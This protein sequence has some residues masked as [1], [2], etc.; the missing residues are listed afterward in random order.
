VRVSVH[1]HG[2]SAGGDGLV[3]APDGQTA[4]RAPD[5]S[6]LLFGRSN[7]TAN[8]RWNRCADFQPA[9]LSHDGRLGVLSA[10]DSPPTTNDVGSW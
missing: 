7:W 1:A 3:A 6:V 5:R 4:H 10:V 9:R 2:L 8:P